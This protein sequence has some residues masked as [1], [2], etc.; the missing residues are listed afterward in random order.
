MRRLSLSMIKL[1]RGT[2]LGVA[3]VLLFFTGVDYLSHSENIRWVLEKI[4]PWVSISEMPELQLTVLGGLC[5]ILPL[6]YIFV[7]SMDNCLSRGILGRG[8]NG[9]DICL[10]AEAVS[11]TVTTEVRA[12]VPDVTKVRSCTVS[13]G[14]RSAHVFI[15]IAVSDQSPVPDIQSKVRSSIQETLERLIGY[16]D[17][18][19][20]RVRVSRIQNSKPVQRKKRRSSSTTAQAKV[21]TEES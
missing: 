15:D 17:G 21:T 10:T 19:Q 9:E 13:Q 11:R 5:L 20:V 7:A 6:V 12:N 3:L 14:R 1:F 8:K 18:K 2:I 16:A 4:T